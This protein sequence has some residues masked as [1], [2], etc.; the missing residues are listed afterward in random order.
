MGED[1]PAADIIGTDLSPIQPSWAPPNCR[2]FIDDAE[3]D[4]AFAPGEAFDYIHARTLGGGIGD[5]QK[6][7]K[8]AFQHLKPGGW[9]EVQEFETFAFSD[10]GTHH[11]AVTIMDWTK[12]VNDAS[13]RF[14]KPMNIAPVVAE[15]M[16]KAG[17]VDVHDDS[18]KV[19]LAMTLE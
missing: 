19:W 6:L 4:W 15:M 18:Y 16:P 17:F 7:L 12:R 10:D 8:Q 2:F 1:F 5:W 11:S 3:S 14:G 9:F 13:R